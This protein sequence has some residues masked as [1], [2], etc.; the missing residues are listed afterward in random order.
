VVQMTTQQY[1]AY[2]ARYGTVKRGDAMLICTP[3][4]RKPAGP[5]Q[6]FDLDPSEITCYNCGTVVHKPQQCPRCSIA[7]RNNTN[8]PRRS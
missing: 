7:I 6:A 4:L 1:N 8:D 5:A 3:R 2:A